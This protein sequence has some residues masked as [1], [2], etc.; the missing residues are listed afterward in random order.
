[1]QIF[2]DGVQN[3][4]E[5]LPHPHCRETETTNLL[6]EVALVFHFQSVVLS[7]VVWR[8]GVLGITARGLRGSGSLSSAGS[9]LF[10]VASHAS[11]HLPLK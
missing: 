3:D 1:M 9:E 8:S 10:C 4:Q 7:P 11:Y 6:Q 5:I 2:E